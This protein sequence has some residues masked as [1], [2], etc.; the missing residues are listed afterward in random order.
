MT[1][2]FIAINYNNSHHT[3]KYIENVHSLRTPFGATKKVI[4]VDNNSKDILGNIKEAV[5]RVQLENMEAVL[6]ESK[7]NLGYFGGLN[8]G[9]NAINTS[10]KYT[11]IIGNNDLLF[12][13]DFLIKL[14]DLKLKKQDYCIAPNV[15]LPSGL[16]QNPHVLH[17][18][19]KFAQCRHG[20]YYKNFYLGQLMIRLN[21]RNKKNKRSIQYDKPIYIHG[22]IG[23]VYILTPYFFKDNKELNAPV[24]LYGEEIIFSHQIHTTGGKIL[25]HPELKVLHN[26]HSSISK[27]GKKRVYQLGKEAYEIYKKY[28]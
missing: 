26:E 12:E 20:L 4:I 16:K 21:K 14:H 27:L 9:I 10:Q 5:F 25:Y 22:G 1:Y 23:A 2:Y 6:V 19:S 11:T 24:F 28:Y 15:Y 17:R 18:P 13:S 8:I 3:I 7:I